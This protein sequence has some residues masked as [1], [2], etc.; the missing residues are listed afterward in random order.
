MAGFGV[1]TEVT[2]RKLTDFK[3]DKIA[4]ASKQLGVSAIQRNVAVSALFQ[5][6]LEHLQRNEAAK[7]EYITA[8]RTNSERSEPK[9]KAHLDPFFGRLLPKD[10]QNNLVRYRQLRESEGASPATINGE[11]RLLSAALRRGWKNGRVRGEHLPKEYPFNN[12]GEKDQARTGTYTDDQIR[13]IMEHATSQFKPLFMTLVF[14]GL[15]PKECR[16]IKRENV[17]LN[18]EVPRILV[19]NHK[20]AAKTRE[21][22]IVAIVDDLLPTLKE[23]ETQTQQDYPDCEWFFHVNGKRFDADTLETEWSRVRKASNIPKGTML[24]DAR[25][26]H[27]HLLDRH[28][29]SKD[30]R[31]AQMGHT[32]D[33]MSDL[34]NQ[35]SIAGARRIREAFRPKA[36]TGPVT[37]S[38]EPPK[39]QQ[40]AFDWKTELAQ[41][42]EAF[43][44]GLLPDDLYRAEIASVMQR[45]SQMR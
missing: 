30:D 36:T 17:L 23:W 24:Y 27:S 25:R 18:N 11:F 44:A 31:K 39:A 6:Y 9:I 21:P 20:T 12:D 3:K 22:K 15:R 5:N 41:L 10:V 33:A 29:V 28:D 32:T 16:W 2:L 7:G 43:D 1:F 34:Y 13:C 40:T 8:E 38:P 26:T 45:R 35:T 19:V 4:E 42:K 14:C 37:T